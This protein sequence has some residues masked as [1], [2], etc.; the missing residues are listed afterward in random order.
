MFF[1]LIAIGLF[2][3]L[4]VLG[5]ILGKQPTKFAVSG[6]VVLGALIFIWFVITIVS[7]LA[8]GK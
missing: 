7:I 5:K 1:L 4:L 3:F 8:T 2:C 6:L